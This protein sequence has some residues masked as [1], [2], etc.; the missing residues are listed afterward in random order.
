VLVGYTLSKFLADTVGYSGS[1][2][3]VLYKQFAQ[4]DITRFQFFRWMCLIA[5]GACILCFLWS[6]RCFLRKTPS[7]SSRGT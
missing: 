1:V 6:L 2:S 4:D 3:M 7:S 5:S